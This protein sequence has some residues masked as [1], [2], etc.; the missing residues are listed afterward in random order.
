MGIYVMSVAHTL[1][2]RVTASL[3][4]GYGWILWPVPGSTCPAAEQIATI[5]IRFISVATC[6]RP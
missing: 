2:G 3:R 4:S 6:R 1:F 5:A